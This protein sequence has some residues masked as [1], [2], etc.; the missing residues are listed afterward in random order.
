MCV[1]EYL[2]LP[3]S[4]AKFKLSL[5]CETQFEN[6]SFTLRWLFTELCHLGPF[7]GPFSKEI[8]RKWK[9]WVLLK[10]EINKTQWNS[11]ERRWLTPPPH[12]HHSHYFEVWHFSVPKR[13]NPIL[14]SLC[15]FESS[16]T[17]ID[18]CIKFRRPYQNKF[19][20]VFLKLFLCGLPS[21]NLEWNI[22]KIS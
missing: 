2:A 17:P 21:T 13:E 7:L 1:F 18:I 16:S 14:G 9:W 10:S 3:P 5:F 12:H 8:L 6:Y 4:S 15:T 11:H 19:T 20:L 22:D